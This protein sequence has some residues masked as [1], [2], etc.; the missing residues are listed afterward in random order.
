VL[1]EENPEPGL[2]IGRTMFQAPEVDGV[3]FIY[4]KGLAT[5]TV[6]QVKITDAFAYDIAGEVVAE[7]RIANRPCATAYEN[8]IAGKRA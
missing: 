4:A 3:T 8:E 2:F 7:G 6:V 1:V 5:G